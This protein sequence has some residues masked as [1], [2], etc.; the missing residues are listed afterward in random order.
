M[1]LAFVVPRFAHHF[2][3]GGLSSAVI[4]RPTLTPR[5]VR[6]I[7]ALAL[8]V[9]GCCSA[10][11]WWLAPY[12]TELV[13]GPADLTG[14]IRA[15]A[16]CLLIAAL[17]APAT[18][19]LSRSMRYR[20]VACTDF[21][22][23]VVGYCV[24]SL[25]S[26]L[27]GAG[28]WSLVYGTLGWNLLQSLLSYLLVRHPL[29]PLFDVRAMRD[30]MRFGGKVSVNGFLEYLTSDLPKLAIGRYLGV[31]TA[32]LY[33]RAA[34]LASYPLQQIQQAASKVLLLYQPHP[35]RDRPA[36]PPSTPTPRL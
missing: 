1:A 4:Q 32:G 11:V 33:D 20:A 27:L 17:G 6:V 21:F 29:R 26:A 28:V 14:M 30:V 13:R 25:A 24:V 31:A 15:L 7:L 23:F 9:G 34:L 19:L 18:G 2:A 8:T 12:G 16:L 35:A 22:S 10:A 3:Q 36:S 5:D